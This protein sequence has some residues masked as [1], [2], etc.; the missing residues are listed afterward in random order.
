M[1]TSEVFSSPG[2]YAWVDKRC[3]QKAP[4]MGLLSITSIANPA[5]N[6]WARENLIKQPNNQSA[7]GDARGTDTLALCG[8]VA[9]PR[10][11]V[12]SRKSQIVKKLTS[13]VSSQRSEISATVLV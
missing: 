10:Q 9:L 11:A 7:R 4:L 13:E 3:P 12:T 5:V 1:G 2:V 6:G 8:K